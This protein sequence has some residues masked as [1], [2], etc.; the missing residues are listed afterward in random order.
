MKASVSIHVTLSSMLFNVQPWQSPYHT[1]QDPLCSHCTTCK[2]S[3]HLIFKI[4]KMLLVVICFSSITFGKHILNMINYSAKIYS[5][6]QMIFL[7]FP[8][9]FLSYLLI[10]L[11]LVQSEILGYTMKKVLIFSLLPWFQRS[12]M[13]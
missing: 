2:L 4:P 5:Y 12:L 7:V 10:V 1:A 13:T 3:Q 6:D 11:A 8:F 9:S